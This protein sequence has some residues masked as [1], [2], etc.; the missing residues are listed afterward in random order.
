MLLPPARNADR[1]LRRL[2]ARMIIAS[3]TEKRKEQRCSISQMIGYF[4]GR[5]E[6]LWAEGVNL[7]HEG[8]LCVSDNPI[9][10]LTNLYLML[11][12][13][14]GGVTK[15]L[16]CEGYVKHS[17]MEGGRCSFGVKIE[18]MSDEDRLHLNAYL[19][20]REASQSCAD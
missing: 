18:T 15:T 4:P 7:S 3:M 10:P 19:A 8:L 14:A 11:E 5:E 9:E 1:P 6:Y 13:S 20:E 2:A 17:H 16:R 12:L